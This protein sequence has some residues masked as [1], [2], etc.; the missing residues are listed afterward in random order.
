MMTDNNRNVCNVHGKK[1]IEK[2]IAC[3]LEASQ[4]G[5]I[6]RGTRGNAVPVVKKL[7]GRMGMAFPM[8]KCLR[9]HYGRHYEQLSGPKCH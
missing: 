5:A 3:K 1:T 7:P 9:T 8:L 6:S 2:C 4:A